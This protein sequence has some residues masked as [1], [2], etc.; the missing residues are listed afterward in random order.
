MKAKISTCREKLFEVGLIFIF[1]VVR[2]LIWLRYKVNVEGLENLSPDKLSK[3]GGILFLPNHPAEIDPVILMLALWWKFRARP[4]VVENFYYLKGAYFFMQC[5]NAMPLPNMDGATNKWKLKKIDKLFNDITQK[6]QQG[7]NFLIYPAGRLKLT[8]LEVIGGA[9]M[10]HNLLKT[11]PEAN[12][13]LIRTTGMWGS[14]FSRALTGKVPD[15][16]GNLWEGAKILLKNGIFFTPRREVKVQLE[17]A[18]A[19]FPYTGSRIEL[20][21]YL[22]KWYNQYP[23]PGPEPIKLVSYS[24][25][26]EEFPQVLTTQ[27][28]KR[29]EQEIFISPAVEKEVFV[30]LAALSRRSI[31]QIERNMHLSFDLGLDSLDV[32]QLYLFLDE[33]FDVADLPQ[34][35]LQT[36]E[37]VL[38][39]AAGYKKESDR[40]AKKELQ[41]WP[42][43]PKRAAPTIPMGKTIQEAFLAVC[44]QRK[45]EVA[46]TDISSGLLTYGK[47]KMAALVLAQKI[48]KLPGENIGILL[49]STTGTYIV[50]LATLLA[51]KIPVMLNWTA[52]VRSLDHAL[53]MTDLQ[54]VFS[55]RRFLD[56]LE[57]GDLGTLEEKLLLL[58]DFKREIT[59]KDKL[60]GIFQSF[61]K[62]ADLLEE[63]KLN[64]INPDDPAVILFTSGTESL[65]KGVPLSHSNLICNQSAA[66]SCIELKVDDI[67]YGVLPPFH[68]FGFSVTG[69]LPIL[70]GLKV[71]YAPDPTDSHGL[72][73]DIYRWQATFF[74]CAP[75][76]IIPLF[77]IANPQH[78]KSVRLFVSGAEKMP[79][80]LQD[81]VAKLGEGHQLIEGYGITECGPIVT[82]TYVGRPRKGVGQPL[83]GVELCIIDSEARK[84]LPMGTEGE[85][86][87]RGPN[88]FKG[89]LGNLPSPFVSLEEKE[90]YRSGDRGHL[91]PDNFLILSGRIK[92][93]VKI[94]GEMVSLGGLEEEL[95]RLAQE[96]RW[97]IVAAEGP[98]LA[99]SVKERETDKPRIIL[100]T[101]FDISK[102]DVNAALKDCGYGR[103]VKITEVKRLPQIPL[104]GTGK[105]HYRY[106]DDMA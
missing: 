33:K 51:K 35:E 32:A 43:E 36:V 96:K 4:L 65:P 18:P 16:G 61:K 73:S 103:I 91:E 89:Y 72:V 92:R 19:D 38:A 99:I 11:C 84:T 87:I 90:W 82:M 6:L 76:F 93:F 48:R 39:A 98:P 75:S 44:T 52:G 53:K 25:W 55:A 94:A 41:V 23:K 104:T 31:G 101:T 29:S 22:E 28:G 57:N 102:E 12:I 59:W 66:I 27:E 60:I 24:F 13:V 85:I 42:K 58:E 10:V 5:V 95:L 37:D 67:L 15:F 74:V 45:G 21:K 78:L 2:Y 47:I 69:L 79:Q 68:S 3:K 46:C 1:W 34:G 30:T 63:L 106:L 54:V 8:G 26:K 77:R 105:T 62:P 40:E 64:Q 7:D 14:R 83:P 81:Y 97:V 80:E 88:V 17:A 50:I 71:C 86:C 49:P 9:S 70:A 56:K 20:N 100:Y